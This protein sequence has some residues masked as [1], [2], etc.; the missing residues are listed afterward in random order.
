MINTSFLGELGK[1]IASLLIVSSIHEQWQGSL[2]N[3]YYSAVRFS[4]KYLFSPLYCFVL[5]VAFDNIFILNHLINTLCMV[6]LFRVGRRH[7]LPPSSHKL[8]SGVQQFQ[9]P[10]SS[11]RLPQTSISTGVTHVKDLNPQ[12]NFVHN[13]LSLSSFRPVNGEVKK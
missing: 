8:S 2:K 9:S 11:A 10:A 4:W 13:V 6:L 3:N 7:I 12:S 5:S 1:E